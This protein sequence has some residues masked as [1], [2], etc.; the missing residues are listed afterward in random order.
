ML[1]S[2]YYGP[3]HRIHSIHAK[4]EGELID[5]PGKVQSDRT[6]LFKYLN[7]NLVF[8]VVAPVSPDPSSEEA[9][10]L[11]EFSL[12]DSVNGAVIFSTSMKRVSDIKAV[13]SE[14]WVVFSVWNEKSRRTELTVIELYESGMYFI[15]KILLYTFV[16]LFKK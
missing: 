11:H 16:V 8:L 15:F 10:H 3:T 6:V 4:R 2:Q 14:N 1:W 12:I 13:H 5:S 7:P 9:K